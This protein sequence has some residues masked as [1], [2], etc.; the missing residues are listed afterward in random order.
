MLFTLPLGALS[1]FWGACVLLI[2]PSPRPPVTSSVF[3]HSSSVLGTWS[4]WCA[5]ALHSYSIPLPAHVGIS[6]GSPPSSLHQWLS[7]EVN[8][9]LHRALRHRL[10]AMVS[11]LHGVLVDVSSD[12]F[13]PVTQNPVYSFNLPPSA[14]HLWG[15]ARWGHDRSSTVTGGVLPPAPSAMTRTAPSCIIFLLALPTTTLALSGLTPV[16]SPCPMLLCWFSTAGFSTLSMRRT[17]RKLSG[18]TSFSVATSVTNSNHRVGDLLYV[19]APTSLSLG[20]CRTSHLVLETL[21]LL[22]KV[23]QAFATP[24]RMKSLS[25]CMRLTVQHLD[26][27]Y[28]TIWWIPDLTLV[29]V[30]TFSCFSRLGAVFYHHLAPIL[31][32][33]VSTLVATSPMARRWLLRG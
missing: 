16:A 9:R 29:C 32:S 10:S 2:M 7:R 27:R 30:H 3:R 17:L 11:D 23:A 14:F 8:P 33:A 4:Y 19:L 5:S 25:W 21:R 26:V 22:A 6:T 13:L 24:K 1:R 12:N 20:L 28:I 18:P 31:L 15:L